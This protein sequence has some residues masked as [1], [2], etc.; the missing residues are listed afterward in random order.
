MDLLSSNPRV[1]K[2]LSLLVTA[3]RAE[4]DIERLSVQP[5]DK[6]MREMLASHS[7]TLGYVAGPLRKRML[8]SV[9][10]LLQDYILLHEYRHVFISD[11]ATDR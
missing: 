1:R 11:S 7:G 8:L 2:E 4:D 5:T 3:F 6:A 9:Y 10:R